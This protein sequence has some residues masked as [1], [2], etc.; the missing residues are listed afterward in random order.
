MAVLA[1]ILPALA[2]ALAAYGAL[3]AFDRH[4]KLYADAVRNLGGLEEPDLATAG[5][6]REAEE[7]L[8]R[9]VEQV[10]KIFRDE[11]SQWGQLAAEPKPGPAA[12]GRED[13]P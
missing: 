4:A 9:Y 11:Q 1:A 7:A 12:S 10:E 5:D 2:T 6:D 3:F 13:A 8:T